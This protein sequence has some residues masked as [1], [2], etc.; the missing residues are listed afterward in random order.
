M[1]RNLGVRKD[2]FFRGP[3]TEMPLGKY[4]RTEEH[5]QKIAEALKG[6]HVSERTEFKV[7]SFEERFWAKVEVRGPDD[8]WLWKG[9]FSEGY[10]QFSVGSARNPGHEQAPRVAWT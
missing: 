10:G 6:K 9:C 3:R 5:S 8:C 7:K 4:V 1:R 2:S